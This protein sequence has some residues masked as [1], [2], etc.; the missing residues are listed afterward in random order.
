MSELTK[1]AEEAAKRTAELE[2]ETAAEHERMADQSRKDRVTARRQ[3][4]GEVKRI[5][6]ARGMIDEALANI[7]DIL[8]SLDRQGL[9]R[10]TTLLEAATLRRPKITSEP[11]LKL[12]KNKDEQ[13]TV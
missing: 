1:L 9:E 7:S 13:Q 4:E 11:I 12:L 8:D 2:R 5:V 10:E 6:K 3:I